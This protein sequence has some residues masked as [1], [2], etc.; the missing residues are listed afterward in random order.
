MTSTDFR[1]SL[2][3]TRADPPWIPKCPSV[4]TIW[5]FWSVSTIWSHWQSIGCLI[6][7]NPASPADYQCPLVCWL[8]GLRRN[9]TLHQI[10]NQLLAAISWQTQHLSKWACLLTSNMIAK[11][12]LPDQNLVNIAHCTKETRAR[13][14]IPTYI[15]QL[16]LW[17]KLPSIRS[18]I[19]SLEIWNSEW[20]LSQTFQFLPFETLL[21]QLSDLTLDPPFTPRHTQRVKPDAA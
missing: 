18:Q 19:R 4:L 11:I 13:I 14:V 15:Y 2:K 7:F 17:V 10:A 20:S 16:S 9:Q 6:T 12:S 3:H 1:P 8:N 5:V 21:H